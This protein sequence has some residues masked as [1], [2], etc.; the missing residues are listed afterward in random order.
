MTRVTCAFAL[1]A[2]LA[3]PALAPAQGVVVA[4]YASPVVVA[5]PPVVTTYYAA[6][7]VSYY[8]A[9]AVSYYTAPAA[10][11]YRYPLL[12]PRTT[13]V[14]VAPAVAVPAAAYYPPGVIV[15]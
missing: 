10:V 15:R 2:L 5:P 3:V 9:P 4:T 7:V 14:R 1:A 8:S 12:R 6:P 13:V 11:T